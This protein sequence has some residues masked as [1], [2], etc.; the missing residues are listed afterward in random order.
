M[1]PGKGMF[2]VVPSNSMSTGSCDIVVYWG[3]GQMDTMGSI[4]LMLRPWMAYDYIV[5]HVVCWVE[6]LE[7]RRHCS[8]FFKNM[9]LDKWDTTVWYRVT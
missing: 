9:D 1:D 3:Y 4:R 8:I 6:L 5:I 7:Q 2:E